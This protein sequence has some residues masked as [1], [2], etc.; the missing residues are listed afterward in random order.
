[1]PSDS[2]WPE[3]PVIVLTLLW[4]CLYG[5][6]V[7][8]IRFKLQSLSH[9]DTSRYP[10]SLILK[11]PQF[12]NQ[13]ASTVKALISLLAA[14]TIIVSMPA[15]LSSSQWV[16][17]PMPPRAAFFYWNF[18]AYI[19]YDTAYEIFLTDAP[20]VDLVIVGHHFLYLFVTL[21]LFN[22][23]SMMLIAVTLIMQELST[24][25]LNAMLAMKTLTM[26]NTKL[27]TFNAV[28][29]TVS[30]FVCRVINPIAAL[31]HLFN[32]A[33]KSFFAKWERSAVVGLVCI[34]SIMQI[35]WF[36]RI[37][38]GMIKHFGTIK[39]LDSEAE[40]LLN[41]ADDGQRSSRL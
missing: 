24:P 1:M 6:L 22:D 30:F 40:K 15:S 8:V 16:V 11:A 5:V 29:L 3:Q 39:A 4:C 27:F 2:I 21:I 19:V 28:A 41:S 34:G 25:F 33:D 37:S 7:S 18:I 17:G 35:S 32:S 31:F 13:V 38:H 23:S 26:E 20:K 9:R 14:Y 36:V 10:D 12:A